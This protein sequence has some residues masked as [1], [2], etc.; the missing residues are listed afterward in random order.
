VSPDDGLAAAR[1]VAPVDDGYVTAGAAVDH[2]A[3]RVAA[4][5][6]VVARTGRH[7]V[8]AGAGIDAVLA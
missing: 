3:P 1:A 6:P 2:V 5:D 7:V 4:E 8:A